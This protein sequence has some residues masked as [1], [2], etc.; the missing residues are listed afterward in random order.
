MGSILVIKCGGSTMEQ[1][2]ADFFQA[3]SELQQTG[4][5]LVIVHG[6]GPAIN[7]MLEKVQITPRFVDGLRYTCE[8]TLEV[9]EMVLSGSINKQLVRRIS[10]SGGKAWG[11]SGVDGG[12]ITA[13]QTERPLGL[14]GEIV[15]VESAMLKHLLEL[16]YIPV[17]AP[18]AASADGQNVYNCNADVAAGAVAAALGADKLLM[19]T[20]VPG[21]CL[22]Q[23]DGEMQVKSETDPAEINQLIEKGIIYGGMIPKVQSAV[24]ALQQGVG[25]VVICR[26]TAAD[27]RDAV[28]GRPVGTAIKSTLLQ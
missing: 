12:L 6:G 5:Q 9:V 2:P 21:I 13:R 24:D 1:L 4:H 3:M 27:L 19:V 23:A 20:D 16:G 15:H 28:I 22:P 11:M 8:A 14:V 26:G 10:Q 25:Q 7:A 17:V 18:L